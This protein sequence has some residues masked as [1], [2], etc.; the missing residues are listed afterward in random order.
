MPKKIVE[1]T[2]YTV[3]D[4]VENGV[5]ELSQLR[6]ELQDWYDNLP[7]NFQSGEKGSQLEEAIGEL[8]EA[9]GF[10]N[11]ALVD[12]QDDEG[13][14]AAPSSLMFQFPASTKRRMS[15]AD[16][17]SEATAL[18]RAAHERVQEWLGEQTATLTEKEISEAASDAINEAIDSVTEALDELTNLIDRAEGVTFPGMYG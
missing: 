11:S 12:A 4:A 5:S 7:E 2:T 18:L 9:D 14:P 3:A 6:D 13:E 17:C 8:D 16:R 10:D 15:R 1:P